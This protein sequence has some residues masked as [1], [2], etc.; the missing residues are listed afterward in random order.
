MKGLH[1]LD[2]TFRE[3][4]SRNCFIS[5]ITVA[6]LK[7]GV[8]NSKAPEKNQVVLDQFLS[9]IQILPIFPALDTYAKEKARLRKS[10]NIIDD[11]D[12]LIGA[13]A[14]AFDLVMVTN[15]TDHFKRIKKIELEDWT[16]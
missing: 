4:G 10:G 16:E 6:E 2:A 13:T 14:I 3:V 12:L 9:G 1:G 7:F 11:F 8:T 15:N 5:E